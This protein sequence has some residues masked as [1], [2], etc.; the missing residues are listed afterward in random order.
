FGGKEERVMSTYLP[1]CRSLIADYCSLLQ[2]PAGWS[3]GI[4]AVALAL[5]VIATFVRLPLAASPSSLSVCRDPGDSQP[6]LE[7]RSTSCD[8]R[9]EFVTVS[10]QVLNLSGRLLNHTEVVVEFYGKGGSLLLVESAMLEIP[11]L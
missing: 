5:T 2:S 10:G 9:Y 11:N 7:V 3:V 1:H 4:G 8:Q 6:T